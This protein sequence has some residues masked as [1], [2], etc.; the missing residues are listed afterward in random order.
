VTTDVVSRV[1]VVGGGIAGVST[2]AALRSSGYAGDLILIDRAE[3]PYDRPPLSKEYLT[4]DRDAKQIALQPAEWYDDQRVELVG[5]AEVASVKPHDVAVDVHLRDGR[6]YTADR[7]V[8]ATGGRAVVPAIPGLSDIESAGRMHVLRDIE[9]ADRLR[10]CLC[11]GAR[12]LVVGGGLI[13]AETAAAARGL[14]CAVTLVDPM[15]PPLVAAGRDVARWLHSQHG[16]AGIDT[17]AATVVSVANTDDSVR[18]KLTDGSTLEV[19]AVLLGVGMVPNIELAAAAG[20]EIDRGVLVDEAQVTSHRRV[21]AIG[22]AA[23]RRGQAPVEHWEAAKH[24]GQRAAA[25]LLGAVVP[26][27]RAPWWWSDRHGTHVEGVG[28]MRDPDDAHTVVIRGELGTPP[29]SVFTVHGG[30]VIGA[31]AVNDSQAV[32][33]ARRLIDRGVTVDPVCLADTDTGLRKLLRG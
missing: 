25:T 7:V 26:T 10:A 31:V 3:L 28:V 4:G 17:R 20:L 13:G 12:L 15:D 5:T 23:Q 32:R 6:S 2:A 16:R 22:D 30:R 27:A 29:F 21:L 19:D 8:L 1:V 14:G 11:P 33:A 18:A 24:D 9:H